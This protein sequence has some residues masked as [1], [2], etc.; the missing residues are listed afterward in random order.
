MNYNFSINK[1]PR[2]MKMK[3]IVVA[4]MALTFSVSQ[5]LV[6]IAGGDPIKKETAKVP[7]TLTVDPAKSEINWHATKVGGEHKGI[8]KLAKGTLEV[9][10]NKLKGGEFEMN[11]TTI[12]D[13]D[14]DTPNTRLTNHLRSDDFFSVEKHPSSTFR[15]TKAEPIAKAK[16]GE[17][18]YT[19]TGDLTIKGVTHPN[20]FP[21]T[22]KIAGNGAEATAKVTVNRMKYD[23]QYRSSFLGTAADK[24]IYD[25]FTIDLKLVAGASRAVAGK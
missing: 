15:I 12:V 13:T 14:K 6:A 18:N 22:V 8:V 23:I 7:S 20:T 10:G 25:D 5:G 19:I 4:A 11:M 16:P 1:I 17:P 3:R 21:A 2:F 24:I 9:D